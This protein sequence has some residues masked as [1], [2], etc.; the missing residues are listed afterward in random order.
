MIAFAASLAERKGVKLPRGLKSNG[1]ICR[2]FLDQHAPARSSEPGERGPQNGPRPPSEA[3]VRYARALAEQNGVE[4]PPEIA[5]DFAACRAFL[6]AHAPRKAARPA[7]RKGT[8]A[9]KG[10]LPAAECQA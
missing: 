8:A 1:A 2:A 10:G 7:G 6:D 4:C 5:T 3:M 9:R